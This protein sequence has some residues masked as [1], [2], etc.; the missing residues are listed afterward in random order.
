MRYG[1]QD[2]GKVTEMTSAVARAMRMRQHAPP[3]N[4]AISPLPCAVASK[5]TKT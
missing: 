5:K 2:L 4:D 1:R 3:R